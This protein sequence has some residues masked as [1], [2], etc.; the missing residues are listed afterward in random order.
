MTK[1]GSKTLKRTLDEVY[2]GTLT[3]AEVGAGA[4]AAATAGSPIGTPPVVTANVGKVAKAGGADAHTI[5][6]LW[7]QKATLVGKTVTIRGVVVKYNEAVM[8]KNWLHLQDGSGDAKA[9]TNDITVTSM[10][11]AA[12]GQ[13]VTITGIV[14]TNKDFGAGYSYAVI[15]EDARVVKK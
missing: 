11:T 15:I 4:P 14:R 10:D 2:F 12:P 8:A 7:A 3:A 13:T 9:G 6:E 1:V 5:A